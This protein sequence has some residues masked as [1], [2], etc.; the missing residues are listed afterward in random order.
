[1]CSGSYASASEALEALQ[2]AQATNDPFHFVIADYQMPGIDGASL[3]TVV[4]A[5]PSMRDVVF[6]MLT[7]VGN[8]RQFGGATAG[9]IDA[10]LVKPVRNSRLM[11]T[12]VTIWSKKSPVVSLLNG[13][14]PA[15]ASPTGTGARFRISEASSVQLLAVHLRREAANADPRVLV[16]E[17]NAVNQRVA[18]MMLAG[19]GIRADVVGNGVRVGEYAQAS[20]LRCRAHGL[21][22]AGDE[23]LRSHSR[24]PENGRLEPGREYHCDDRRRYG[25]V[26]RAVSKRGH[27]RFH[28]E[29]SQT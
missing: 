7:S 19:L 12:L 2:T 6:I 15:T 27:G 11:D 17:D 20:S 10:C 29:A 24:H 28:R 3:A 14:E 22:N 23:R 26:P 5:N 9:S 4:R 21:S 25:R 13:M 8:W 16:V 1:M 18:L